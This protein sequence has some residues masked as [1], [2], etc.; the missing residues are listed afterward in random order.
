LQAGTIDPEEA[1]KAFYS[2]ELGDYNPSAPAIQEESGTEGAPLAQTIQEEGSRVR[3]PRPRPGAI[4]NDRG[5]S[6]PRPKPGQNIS[7]K[8]IE[9]A[10]E[11]EAELAPFLDAVAWLGFDIEK[12]S[13]LK[14]E[15][16]N[17]MGL[18][19]PPDVSDVELEE[20]NVRYKNVTKGEA[21]K[22]DR[23]Y[24]LSDTAEP[25][26]YAHEFRHRGYQL[27]KAYLNNF[28]DP[29]LEKLAKIIKDRGLSSFRY[30]TSGVLRSLKSLQ[31]GVRFEEELVDY[32]D[33]HGSKADTVDRE[34][35]DVPGHLAPAGTPNVTRRTK[36]IPLVASHLAQIMQ[37][38]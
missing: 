19:V 27:I 23:V 18:Y 28:K 26:I 3:K 6:L 34:D 38:K 31:A 16:F 7:Q 15:G 24:V 22:R 17:L 20:S 4:V 37:G 14:G 5:V 12:S 10:I 32:M 2:L 25:S 36:L 11:F 1:S 30:S 35:Q 13:L 8:N 9:L 21:L 29:D 33:R